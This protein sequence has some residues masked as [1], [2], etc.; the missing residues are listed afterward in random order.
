LLATQGFTQ[1]TFW[2]LWSKASIS[3]PF[4]TETAF[5]KVNSPER[6]FRL[7]QT[8]QQAF[9]NVVLLQKRSTLIL[10]ELHSLEFSF[11]LVFDYF[12]CYEP[13]L[14]DRLEEDIAL[15]GFKAKPLS[16]LPSELL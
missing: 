2:C 13:V 16:Y 14:W 6:L 11:R 8:H 7:F 1:F 10:G 4:G 12:G 3:I 9:G 15:K 5:V